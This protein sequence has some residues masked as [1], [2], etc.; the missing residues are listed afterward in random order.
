MRAKE[1]RAGISVSG[2]IS[3][4][5]C[6]SDSPST[7]AATLTAVSCADA[8]SMALYMRE[9]AYFCRSSRFVTICTTRCQMSSLTK[10]PAMLSSCR[11][12]STYLHNQCTANGEWK[13]IH[14]GELSR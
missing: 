9:A 12:V 3:A 1:N 10:S 4:C 5:M 7:Y 13:G 2:S 6:T 11:I 14:G 8:G